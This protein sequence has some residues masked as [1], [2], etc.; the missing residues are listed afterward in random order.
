M[1]IDQEQ[2]LCRGGWDTWAGVLVVT[3]W[4]AAWKFGDE[5]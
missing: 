2:E 1:L 4:W 3:K 5:L